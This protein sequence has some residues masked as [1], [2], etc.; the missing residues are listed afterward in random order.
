MNKPATALQNSAGVSE[1]VPVLKPYVQIS[2]K[3]I[4]VCVVMKCRGL[5]FDAADHLYNMSLIPKQ[6]IAKKA[7]SVGVH[8]GRFPPRMGPS[9]SLGR[10]RASP[11][12][13]MTE[14][15]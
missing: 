3:K 13:V 7:L 15:V 9:M 6:H 2:K 12:W 5:S 10:K 8:M 1:R 11:K 14:V 4:E